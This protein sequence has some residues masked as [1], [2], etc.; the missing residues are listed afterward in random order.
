MLP[1]FHLSG[2]RFQSWQGR[3]DARHSAGSAPPAATPGRAERLLSAAPDHRSKLLPVPGRPQCYRRGLTLEPCLPPTGERAAGRGRLDSR[4]QARR[5]PD[6]G[7]PARAQ[8]APSHAQRPRPRGP[9]PAYRG[10]D[11]GL[12]HRRA[13]STERRSSATTAAWPCSSSSGRPGAHS[14]PRTCR[15]WMATRCDHAAGENPR[16]FPRAKRL[17]KWP[18][19]RDFAD[20]F[21]PRERRRERARTCRCLT[22]QAWCSPTRC[23]RCTG[24]SG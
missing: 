1:Q 12:A 6:P 20:H 22:P 8:R 2:P 21:Q 17:C 24:T 4:D 13:S 15:R 5:L 10:S 23:R 18:P 11:R 16:R 19:G 3:Q 14:R 7:A 9:F